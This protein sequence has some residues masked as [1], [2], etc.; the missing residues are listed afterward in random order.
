MNVLGRARILKA[1]AHAKRLGPEE[2]G[3][4][5]R[6]N[7]LYDHKYGCQWA[8]ST[9]G[10]VWIS[11]GLSRLDF[12]DLPTHMYKYMLWLVNGILLTSSRSKSTGSSTL[13]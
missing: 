10:P 13:E 8:W 6:S 11:T 1:R 3:G 12:N 4:E 7:L 5:I 2:T 9:Q